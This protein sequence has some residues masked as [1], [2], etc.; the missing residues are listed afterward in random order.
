[1]QPGTPQ[2]LALHRDLADIGD[3]LAVLRPTA[4]AAAA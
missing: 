3:L 1:V 2:R 4:R